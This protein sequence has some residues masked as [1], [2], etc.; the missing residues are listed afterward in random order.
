MKTLIGIVAILAVV[1]IAYISYQYIYLHPNQSVRNET[2][3]FTGNLGIATTTLNGMPVAITIESCEDQGLSCF[4]SGRYDPVR[5]KEFEIWNTVSTAH[6]ANFGVVVTKASQTNFYTV[7]FDF[8]SYE[9]SDEEVRSAQTM[10]PNLL[11]GLN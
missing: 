11:S 8:G 4:G 10:I 1:G 6:R 9:Y 3:V 5:I 7:F 2:P